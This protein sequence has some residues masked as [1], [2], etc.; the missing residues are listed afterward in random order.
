MRK[1]RVLDLFSGIGGF[2]LGLERTG[3]F[4]TTAFC[5]IEPFPRRVLAKRWP[6]VPIHADVRKLRGED[7]GP[8]DVICGGYP[9]QPFSV[10]GVRAGADDDRHLWPEFARLVDELRPAWVIGENVA[11][12]ISMGLDLVLSDLERL[13]YTARPFVIPA[14]G[15]GAPHRR[16]RVWIVAHRNRI[17]G[18]SVR[19]ECVDIAREGRSRGDDGSRGGVDA[20]REIAVRGA[21]KNSG[22]ASHT[23]GV[24]RQGQGK[25]FE[26]I[27]SATDGDGEAA[28]LEH[29]SLPDKR[30]AESGMGR[31]HDGI[32]AWLDGSWE[33]GIARVATGVP[34]KSARLKAIGN[35]VVPQI[36]EFIGRAIL[37]AEAGA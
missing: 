20:Q 13:G 15:V 2:S 23:A 12:H 1:L 33:R 29:G 37:A 26:P 17:A 30:L 21:G 9:C 28:E 11:G 22:D 3:G 7:V 18:P 14:C 5:E 27:N 35:A 25:P 34:D 6:G 24:G 19:G 36:P 16:E 10:A 8:V 31:G 4:E 32:S